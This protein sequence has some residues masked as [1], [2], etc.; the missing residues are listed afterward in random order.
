MVTILS[1]ALVLVLVSNV[2]WV[3]FKRFMAFRKE[4]NWSG[5]SCD[6]FHGLRTV[7]SKRKTPLI[8]KS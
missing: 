2:Y 3:L 4:Q 6:L 8:A 1:P 7:V 5:S